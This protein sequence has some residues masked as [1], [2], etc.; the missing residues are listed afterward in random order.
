VHSLLLRVLFVL[1]F[2]FVLLRIIGEPYNDQLMQ[3]AQNFSRNHRYKKMNGA[4]LPCGT[5][6][7]VEPSDPLYN[8]RKKKRTGKMYG[9][10]SAQ[11]EDYDPANTEEEPKH[12]EPKAPEA[13]AAKDDDDDD[14]DDFFASLT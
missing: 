11:E 13:S 5:A 7:K 8:L 14:L 6:L 9:A 12:S 4:E 1:C 3:C 2:C 10:A